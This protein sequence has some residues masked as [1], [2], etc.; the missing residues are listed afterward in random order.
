MTTKSQAEALVEKLREKY[1]DE[2]ITGAVI[3]LL[4]TMEE[5]K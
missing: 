1:S 2:E 4:K 3:S 5:S